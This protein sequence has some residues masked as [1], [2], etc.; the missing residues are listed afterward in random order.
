VLVAMEKSDTDWVRFTIVGL[1]LIILAGFSSGVPTWW[2]YL[3][4]GFLIGGV[5]AL[6]LAAFE[7]RR[8]NKIISK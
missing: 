8:R 3:D 5:I 7:F 4:Y 6:I 1:V 2:D